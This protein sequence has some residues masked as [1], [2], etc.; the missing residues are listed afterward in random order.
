M[1]K[2]NLDLSIVI[3]FRSD[4]GIR[5]KQLAY[6][7]KRFE[8]V[9]PS[10]EI[11]V[12]EDKFDGKEWVEFNKAKLLNKGVKKSTKNNILILD[13][14]V[15]LPKENIVNALNVI[16]HHGLIFP[17]N[18]VLFIQNQ[19]SKDVMRRVVD[20]P[21]VDMRFAH[22]KEKNN[23]DTW[24]VYMISKEDYVKIGGHE[25]RY[26]GWGGEDGSFISTAMCLIDKPYLRMEGKAYHLYH[27]KPKETR[28]IVGDK[29]A[30]YTR[31]LQARY[32]REEMLEIIKERTYE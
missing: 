13:V 24:G 31:Y 6:Q 2:N 27:D 29:R 12:V 25:E 5:D 28:T 26:V 21:K 1:S 22:E 7:L 19:E 30:L 4:G 11:I 10:V 32:N 9:M 16:K 3:P 14:D 17:F 23:Y 8:L 15:L 18:K 20:V